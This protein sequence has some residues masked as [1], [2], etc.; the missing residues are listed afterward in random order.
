MKTLLLTASL[1][2]VQSLFMFVFG[3]LSLVLF[4]KIWGMTNDVEAIRKHLDNMK[5]KKSVKIGE[6]VYVAYMNK[7]GILK[8]IKDGLATVELE[9]Y[10]DITTPLENV[11]SR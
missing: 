11:E 3:I 6:K 1:A 8:D 7:Y 4:F 10:G 2:D 9:E 5:R